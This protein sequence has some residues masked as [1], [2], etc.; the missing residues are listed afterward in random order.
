MNRAG[1]RFQSALTRTIVATRRILIIDDTDSSLLA[2]Q[3]FF[4]HAEYTVFTAQNGKEGL[5][6]ALKYLPDIIVSDVMMPEMDGF[7]LCH[8]LKQQPTTRAIPIILLTARGDAAS[9]IRGFEA[10]ADEYIPKP[11]DAHDVHARVERILHW[12]DQQRKRT[13][14]MSGTLPNTP[15]FEL[16]RFCQEQRISGAIH[17][18]RHGEHETENSRIRLQAGEI[19]AIELRDITDITV[20]LDELLTWEKD[21]AFTVEQDEP[22]LP[23]HDDLPAETGAE[24][25]AQ[26]QQFSPTL[27]REFRRILQELRDKT[28]SLDYVLLTDNG[29]GVIH[30]LHSP[31]FRAEDAEA[32]GKLIAKTLTFSRKAGESLALGAYQETLLMSEHD[33]LILYPIA[34]VGGL[35]VVTRKEAQGMVRWNCQEAVQ[36]ILDAS[37]LF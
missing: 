29:G 23:Q 14:K 3:K 26:P 35:G 24:S 33:V 30:A 25:H 36:N 12:V 15:F 10:G 37:R 28:E 31:A 16:L 8:Q 11:F 34:P 32:F 22:R 13:S 7:E 19:V 5:E 2:L 18:T 17:L 20:A 9:T 4:Q 27:L 1:M 21:G 6:A